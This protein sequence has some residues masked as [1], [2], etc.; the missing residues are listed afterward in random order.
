M[1][2]YVWSRLKLPI[3]GRV[4]KF[5]SL[6]K[7]L[8]RK[9]KSYEWRNAVFIY[10]R[11]SLFRYCLI[12]IFSLNSIKLPWG[13]FIVKTLRRG[14]FEGGLIEGSGL[15]RGITEF[16]FQ[17]NYIIEMSRKIAMMWQIY[18]CRSNKRSWKSNSTSLILWDQSHDDS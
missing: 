14:L 1:P 18:R 6:N 13:V 15:S 7:G 10:R 5:Y 4:K 2:P 3:W 17:Q 11:G 9:Y 12:L 16:K 8:S